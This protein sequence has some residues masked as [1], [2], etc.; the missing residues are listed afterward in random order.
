MHW[1]EYID[2]RTEEYLLSLTEEEE[3]KIEEQSVKNSV[4]ASSIDGIWW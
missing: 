3:E 1:D 2:Y 4:L